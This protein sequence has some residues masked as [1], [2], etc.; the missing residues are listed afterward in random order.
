MIFSHQLLLL[1][2]ANLAQLLQ[3]VVQASSALT[4]DAAA[5]MIRRMDRT[6]VP[7]GSSWPYTYV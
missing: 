4:L 5:A 7:Y 1:F 2:S 6:S 3:V